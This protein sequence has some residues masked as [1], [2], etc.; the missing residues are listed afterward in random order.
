MATDSERTVANPDVEAARRMVRH[1]QNWFI[2]LVYFIFVGSWLSLLWSAVAWLLMISLVGIPLGLIML[3]RLP[4]V[5]TLRPPLTNAYGERPEQRAFL[6]RAA[7]FV[8]VGSWLS[9]LW[10]AGAWLASITL[11]GIPVGI[12]MWDRVPA[13]TTLARY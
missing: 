5:T 11:I 10:M 8:F 2:T 12:W 7:Y 3:N 13:V 4:Q 9:L 1:G 6:A